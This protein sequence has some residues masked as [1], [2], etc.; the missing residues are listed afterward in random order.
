M[1]WPFVSRAG[2]EA[3]RDVV[4]AQARL[5]REI[6]DDAERALIAERARYDALLDKYH[7]LRVAGAN[8]KEP[9]RI[10]PPAKQPPRP[11][12]HAIRA[13]SPRDDAA[14]FANLKLYR[15]NE[16]EADADPE[17]FAERIRRG[18][19]TGDEPMPQQAD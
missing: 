7:A 13:I 12:M 14:Y 4:D 16:I 2:A 19:L 17:G 1:K 18:R 6:K 5:L 9:D 10:I 8:P 11:I 15:D 3:L